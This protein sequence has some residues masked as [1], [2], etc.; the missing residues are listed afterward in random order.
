MNN[1]DLTY[2]EDDYGFEGD[3]VIHKEADFAAMRKAGRLAAETLDFITPYVK[4]GV[5]TQE[6]D[7]LCHDFIVQH[8]AIPA[9]LNYKG[10]PKSICT[11]VNHVVCHGIP[12]DKELIEGDIVN[13]DVTVIL[14]GWHGD[15]SRMFMVG[16]K[17]PTKAKL[18]VDVTYEAMMKGI[19]IVKPGLHIGD[20]G[21]AIQTFAEGKRYSVVRDFCGHGIGKVFHMPPS[22][23]HYGTKG[24]GPQLKAGMFFTVEPMINA[25]GWQTKILSDGWTA[26]TKDKSLSAQFE[27]TIGVTE[28]GYEIFTASPKGWLHPPYAV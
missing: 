6:L 20:I 10:F 18:L 11:S 22:I 13:I 8:K 21:A 1:Y 5:E 4:P 16:E 7:K 2:S 14:D 23:L 15:T 28:T 27:H 12:S 24:K 25:G 9:P 26:V 19:E 17:I 3:F